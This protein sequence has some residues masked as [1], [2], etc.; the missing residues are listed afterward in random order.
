MRG[1]A[2]M[3]F[4][5]IK[6][7]FHVVGYS[8]DG[9]SVRFMPND[10]ALIKRLPGS[11]PKFN[12]RQHVQLRIEAIDTLETHFSLKSGGGPLHQPLEL[13]RAASQELL[14]Y[15]K[16]TGV[17][18]DSTHM[19]VLRAQDGVEGYILSRAVEKN[20]RPVA[21]VYAGAAPEADGASV[22]LGRERLMESYNHLALARGLAYPT[23]Y[24]GLFNDLR[25]TLTQATQRAREQRAGVHAMDRGLEGFDAV[26]LRSITQQNII[27]P[28]LFRRLCEYMVSFGTAKGFKRKLE[29]AREP[30]LDLRTSNFTHFD[31]FVE[32]E[33]GSTRIHLTRLPEELVFD[34]M[35]QRPTD[36]FAELM[37]GE[38]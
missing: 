25:E 9:D 34:T 36:F 5:L 8:P 33:E 11:R 7:S 19:N 14:D 24:Q 10:P 16:I 12:P 15:L 2:T 13:A 38:S 17:E 23:Y 3:P 20:G 21:F 22:E 1:L 18:W 29:E 30:V 31:T 28:K 6:G 26:D 4:T 35:P 32:Q 37:A 27:L